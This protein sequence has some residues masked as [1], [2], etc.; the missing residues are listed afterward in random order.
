MRRDLR[1]GAF[2]QRV[3]ECERVRDEAARLLSRPLGW[4]SEL[5]RAEL[6]S[7]APEL[8]PILLRRARHVIGENE[9]VEQF[10]DAL[11][12]HAMIEAGHAL[13][14]SHQSLRDDYEVS[15]LEADWLVEHSRSLS[16]MIGAR[17]TGAGFGGCTLHLAQAEHAPALATRLTSAFEQQFGRPGQVH[18]LLPADGASFSL[19]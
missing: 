1:S 18:R 10:A 16:G 15:W 19:G 17:M 12:S 6:E 9:R 3:R 14:A 11:E 5:R 2:E 4:L 8:D 7:I 13:Y